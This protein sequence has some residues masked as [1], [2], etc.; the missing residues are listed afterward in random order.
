M[1][2]TYTHTYTQTP[3]HTALNIL[4]PCSEK[5]HFQREK[6]LDSQTHYYTVE[7]R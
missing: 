6:L 5:G 3:T 1:F 4:F 2:Y 7:I